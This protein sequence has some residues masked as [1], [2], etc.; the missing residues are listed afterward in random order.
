[1]PRNCNISNFCY[2]WFLF[3]LITIFQTI[4]WVNA[5]FCPENTDT[6]AKL[7]SASGITAHRKSCPDFKDKANEF[8]CCPS[9]ITPGT[10][11]CCT[12]EAKE[13]IDA[14]LA[15]EARRIF[16]RNH[17]AHIIIGSI[18]SFIFIIIFTS[19]ICKRVKYCPM[20]H[21]KSLNTPTSQNLSSYR[22]VDTLPPKPPTVYEAPPPYEFTTPQTTHQFTN[23]QQEH[24]WNCLIENE[25]NDARI[26][27]RRS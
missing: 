8:S 26:Y 12:E 3:L 5:E 22:P 23:I 6:V 11:Y 19:V 25:V 9:T 18:L 7:L 14:E 16:F 20:Y 13:E 21:S 4:I 15:A 17:L 2:Q 24:D 27:E 1:M 10:F